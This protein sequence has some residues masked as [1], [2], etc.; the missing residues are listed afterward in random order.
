[1]FFGRAQIDFSRSNEMTTGSTKPRQDIQPELIHLTEMAHILGVTQVTARAYALAGRFPAREIAGR[2]VAART[3]VISYA[4][5]VATQQAAAATA[6]LAELN[7]LAD[8]SGCGT[9]A[10]RAALGGGR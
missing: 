4:I 9:D 1:L 6:R 8:R 10:P 7:E 3:D 2:L 5:G